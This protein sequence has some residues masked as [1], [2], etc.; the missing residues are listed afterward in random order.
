MYMSLSK[1]IIFYR[2][3]RPHAVKYWCRFE[4]ET[5]NHFVNNALNCA[6]EQRDD[7]IQSVQQ[8]YKLDMNGFADIFL[9]PKR[10]PPFETKILICDRTRTLMM[11]IYMYNNIIQYI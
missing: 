5:E 6:M 2:I 11:N 7:W 4:W 8:Y 1:D 9:N 3:T 10:Y